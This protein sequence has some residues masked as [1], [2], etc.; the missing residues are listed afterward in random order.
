[1]LSPQSG[2]PTREGVQMM[3]RAP[4]RIHPF[5]VGP[6]A[7]GF[8]RFFPLLNLAG[9]DQLCDRMAGPL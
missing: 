5:S 7:L 4:F 8:G 9:Y 6:L 2:L 1:M 3:R